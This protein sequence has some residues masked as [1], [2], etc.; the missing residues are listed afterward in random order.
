VEELGR[1]ADAEDAR[2]PMDAERLAKRADLY[3]M[4]TYRDALR[5]RAAVVLFPGESDNMYL[6]DGTMRKSVTLDELLNGQVEGVGVMGFI[7]TG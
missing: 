7:P 4:H 3:K 5:C 1:E 6:T 2:M